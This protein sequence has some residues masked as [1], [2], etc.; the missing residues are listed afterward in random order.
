[1]GFESDMVTMVL[2]I[3]RRHSIRD[4]A[5]GLNFVKSRALI[6]N[7]LQRIVQ[8]MQE[9][10]CEL[11]QA[12]LQAAQTLCPRVTH[13]SSWLTMWLRC[14][15]RQ[16]SSSGTPSYSTQ[17]SSVNSNCQLVSP[18]WKVSLMR[19]CRTFVA[20]KFV[21]QR[22]LYV[23]VIWRNSY[24]S[25]NLSEE[26]PGCRHGAAGEREHLLSAGS[27][28]GG[29]RGRREWVGAVVDNVIVSHSGRPA[30]T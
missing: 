4:P 25:S 14:P 10:E 12:L 28:R 16:T 2:S 23:H 8:L 1:M 7:V 30:E 13:R 24:P 20:Q 21:A 3:S 19:F 18:W 26:C 9:E 29:L 17:E 27:R 6:T 15:D 5:L 22:Q 11:A